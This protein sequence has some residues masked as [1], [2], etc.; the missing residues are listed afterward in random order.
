MFK[1]KL[2]EHII[3]RLGFL[4]T[5]K[6]ETQPLLQLVTKYED[7]YTSREK[8]GPINNIG[9]Q[10]WGL[11]RRRGGNC[12][13]AGVV[14]R[15]NDMRMTNRESNGFRSRGGIYNRSSRNNFI[16][17]GLINNW[18]KGGR[19]KSGNLNCLRG[20]LDREDQSQFEAKRPFRIFVLKMTPVDFPY[21]PNETLV[22]ELWDTCAEKSFISEEVFNIFP[23]GRKKSQMPRWDCTE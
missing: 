8:Q 20:R 19:R 21:V 23:I 7:R 9:R 18:T 22:K 6:G 3:S 14:N 11:D 5:W 1:D 10:D 16:N 4:I 17:R 15:Q 12:R 2:L 13:D